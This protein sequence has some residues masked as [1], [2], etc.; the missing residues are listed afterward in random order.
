M[1]YIINLVVTLILLTVLSAVSMYTAYEVG[2][3]VAKK[4]LID[5]KPIRR[6]P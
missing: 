4:Q 3:L 5:Y 2:Y 1:T 6:N